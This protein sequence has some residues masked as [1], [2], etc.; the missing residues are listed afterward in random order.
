M[1][2]YIVHLTALYKLNLIL[3]GEINADNN[4]GG[5][6]IDV[7]AEDMFLA[8]AIAEELHPGYVAHNVRSKNFLL[9]TKS[10]KNVN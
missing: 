5:L 2:T 8:S 9:A 6:V 4:P 10:I 1:N 3:T 7:V